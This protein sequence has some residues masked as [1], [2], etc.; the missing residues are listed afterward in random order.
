MPFYF[1]PLH[2]FLKSGEKSSPLH[3]IPDTVPLKTSP[4]LTY[5]SRPRPPKNLA[6]PYKLSGLRLNDEIIY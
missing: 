4:P 6:T 1:E 2:L 5:N 3:I